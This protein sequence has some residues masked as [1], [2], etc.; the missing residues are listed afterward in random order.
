MICRFGVITDIHHTNLPDSEKLLHSQALGRTDRFVAAMNRLGAAFIIELG[1][2]IDSAG[3]NENGVHLLQEIEAVLSGFGGPRY[4]VIGNHD[5]DSITRERFLERIVNTG[6]VPGAT[7]YSF[8]CGG[9]HGVVLDAGY[10]VMPPHR[11]FDRQTADAQFFTWED[12][13]IPAEQLA[14]LKND[15]AATSLPT[16]VFT[17]QLLHRDQSEEHTIK[18]ASTVRSILE[19]SGKVLAVFSG[20]DHHGDY[21]VINAIHYYVLQ[22]AIH[23]RAEG[24][25]GPGAPTALGRS[26][27]A[28]VEIAETTTIATKRRAWRIK[29]TQRGRTLQLESRLPA[30][31]S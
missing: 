9:L 3:K 28:L 27:Y 23:R 2:M 16:V 11:P 22:G 10:T 24:I 18:N 26:A 30:F 5:F 6:I 31:G 8:D 20:H 29:I 15:L 19:E 21:A 14:W 17:H 7:Y 1:D 12:A 25:K 13:W 4:H